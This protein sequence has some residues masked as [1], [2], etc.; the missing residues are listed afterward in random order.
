M[1]TK[2]G[3]TDLSSTL[4]AERGLGVQ[5]KPGLQNGILSQKEPT[6]E[7]EASVR[8]FLPE[9]LSLPNN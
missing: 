7:A 6:N 3:G 1:P 5:G 8:L 9:P 4:E 2:H